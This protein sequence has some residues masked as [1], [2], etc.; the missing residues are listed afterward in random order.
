[1]EQKYSNYKSSELLTFNEVPSHWNKSRIKHIGFMY[2]GLTGKSG[3][4]F[5]KDEDDPSNKPF[6]PFTN[7]CNN[8]YIKRDDLKL[9]SITE[10][11]N[12]NRVEKDDIFFM[13]TSE[14]QVDVGKTSVLKEDLGEVYL[15]TFCKGYRITD[16]SVNPYFL[17]YLL[18]GKPYRE[19]LSIQG[20][21]FTRINLRQDRVNDFIVFIPPL[22]EQEQIVKY[23]DEKTSLIDNLISITEKK[24]EILKHKRTSLINEVV[25]KGLNR[26]VEMKDSGVEWIGEIPIHWIISKFNFYIK[27]RHGYQFRDYDFTDSGTKI[28]KITQLHKD[29]FLDLSNCSFIDE[30]RVE[31]FED[32]L[33][34]KDDILMCLTGG[35]IGKI[36]KVG[37]VEEPLLQN[38]RVGHFSSKNDKIII[39]NFLFFLMSSD[40]INGQIFFGIRETGQPNIGL[41]DFGKMK[42]CIPS[43]SEQEEIVE[44]INNNITE[45]DNLVS[46]EQRRIDTLKEYRQS[47]ISEVVTGKIKVTKEETTIKKSKK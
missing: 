42:I 15:N 25:T 39:N 24:I 14:T 45:I 26:D 30:N 7:I 29:G 10:E 20:N 38:Y 18:N 34:K 32:I 8:T 12:Q 4:D 44:Y 37:K 43:I 16:K 47:L 27:L 35:T 31:N 21:G 9:V 28:I 22:P 41:E 17:N 13:M 19:I 46:V 23:L 3:D 40:V 2:G 5:R 1:M 6:I 36:I 11:D 33:I